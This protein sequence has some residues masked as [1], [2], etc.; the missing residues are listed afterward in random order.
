MLQA[1]IFEQLITMIE[2]KLLLL[3]KEENDYQIYDQLHQSERPNN[4][5]RRLRETTK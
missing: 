4:Q 2:G 1:C 3:V 5:G